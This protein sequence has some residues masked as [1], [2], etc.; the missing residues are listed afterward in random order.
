MTA[1]QPARVFVGIKVTDE[2]AQELAELARP[3]ERQGVRL[4]LSI[5][6]H[7]TLVPPWNE[8]DIAAA[9]ATLQ[10]AITDV[11]PFP[12]TFLHLGYGPRLREPRLLWVEC[13]ASAELSD[14]QT[15]LMTAYGKSNSRPFLPHV[16][17]ARLPSNG[18]R[19]ARHNPI[20]RTLLLTQLTTSVELFQSPAQG[21]SGY[22]VFASLPLG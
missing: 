21:Q 11:K 17:L 2:I 8:I 22:R 20:D 14:L 13:A 12:L 10:A 6:I 5:D 16:T 19:I 4:M 15:T 7:L 3:L 18:R 9:V 1:T